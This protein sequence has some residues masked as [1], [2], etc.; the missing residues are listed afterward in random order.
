MSLPTGILDGQDKVT[1][2][3][4]I[5]SNSEGNFFTFALGTDFNKYFFFKVAKDSVRFAITQNTWSGES[6]AEYKVTGTEWHKYTFVIDNYT[7]KT[8][9]DGELL[10]TTETTTKISDL[11]DDLM[12][13]IGKSFYLEDDYFTGSIDNLQIYTSALSDTDVKGL[14]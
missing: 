8:Y 4:D 9:V 14:K 1:I 7:I 6:D 5:K 11:G 3:M 10:G 2:S 12:L 13:W